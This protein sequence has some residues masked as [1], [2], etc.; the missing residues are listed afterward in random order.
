LSDVDYLIVGDGDD[1]PRLEH[2]SRELGFTDRVQF[3][4][5]YDWLSPELLALYAGCEALVLP[6]QGE[7]F[8]LVFL[9]AMAFGKPVV[10]GAHGGTP[11]FVKDGVTG[12]LT[13]YGDV[14]VLADLLGRLLSD[15]RLRSAIGGRARESVRTQYLF[16]HFHAR[17]G[18]VVEEL[19]AA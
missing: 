11:D 5:E 9:E 14:A 18:A 7:G 2:L 6:S 15:E 19:C 4:G 1:R 17:L 3:L 8:G 13:P 16:E 10:G 12:L